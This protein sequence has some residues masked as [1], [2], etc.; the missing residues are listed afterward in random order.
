[1]NI[2]HGSSGIY[3]ESGGSGGAGGNSETNKSTQEEQNNPID[4]LDL[5]IAQFEK[6]KKEGAFL[7][8]IK[9]S[10]VLMVDLAEKLKVEISVYALEDETFFLNPFFENTIDVSQNP[11]DK[12][13]DGQNGIYKD[14]VRIVEQFHYSPLSYQDKGLVSFPGPGDFDFAHNHQVIVNHIDRNWSW[15]IRPTQGPVYNTSYKYLKA[16]PTYHY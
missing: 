4:P 8:D 11:F 9:Y 13:V 14:G 1:M 12:R 7:E 5:F 15:K 3:Q 2:L 6:V 16:W 10:M